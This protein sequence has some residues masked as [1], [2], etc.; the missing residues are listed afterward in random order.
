MLPGALE[1]SQAHAKRLE[2]SKKLKVDDARVK[3]RVPTPSYVL[4]PKPIQR[5][6]QPGRPDLKFVDVGN[7]FVDE[8]ELLSRFKEAERKVQLRRKVR[9]Q[10]R[11]Q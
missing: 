4:K 6:R 1:R 11:Q 10:I 7:K 3:A 5:L 8:K 2:L 9:R